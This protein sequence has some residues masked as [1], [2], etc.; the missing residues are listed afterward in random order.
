MRRLFNR[1]IV[2]YT[3]LPLIERRTLS[4]SSLNENFISLSRTLV[5]HSIVTAFNLLGHGKDSIYSRI[6]W[7][8]VILQHES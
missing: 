1:G 2:A 3:I 4:A 6:V 5:N 7:I 8:G